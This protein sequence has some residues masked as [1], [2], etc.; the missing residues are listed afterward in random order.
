MG[1]EPGE[2]KLLIVKSV[3]PKKMKTKTTNI[4]YHEREAGQKSLLVY[5]TVTTHA[6]HSDSQILKRFSSLF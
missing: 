2:L 4:G 3:N 1:K 5:Y 6:T